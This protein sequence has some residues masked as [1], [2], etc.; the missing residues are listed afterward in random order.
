MMTLTTSGTNHADSRENG[1]L[2]R[3][4]RQSRFDSDSLTMNQVRLRYFTRQESC[5]KR[6]QLMIVW[7]RLKRRRQWESSQTSS[8]RG[9]RNTYYKMHSIQNISRS[10]PSLVQVQ[11]VRRNLQRVPLPV[12]GLKSPIKVKKKQTTNLVKIK[13]KVPSKHRLARLLGSL[14]AKVQWVLSPSLSPV[15]HRKLQ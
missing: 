12:V 15:K 1:E 4:S 6:N 14:S 10:P 7:V 5:C 13:W 11:Q 3:R 9:T 8:F 2:K